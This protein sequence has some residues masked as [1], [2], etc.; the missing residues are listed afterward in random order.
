V[1]WDRAQEATP[2]PALT[3]SATPVASD[4]A[5]ASEV[6]ATIRVP[7]A[8]V[9]PL[10]AIVDV[11]LWRLIPGEELRFATEDSPPSI[12][13]DVVLSGAYTVCSE[14]RLQVQRA[15]GLE[16]V[17]PGTVVTVH[18]GDAVIYVENQAAQTLRNTGAVAPR[19]SALGSTPR[20][21]RPD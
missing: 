2:Q 1:P 3:R 15:M 10:P 8:A 14:G 13:A 16:E 6:L 11:W 20:P 19:P 18:P 9:P 17:P 7:A 4:A 5:I 12:A 21:H